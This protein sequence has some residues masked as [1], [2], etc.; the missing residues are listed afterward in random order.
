LK[1]KKSDEGKK[2][3]D[4]NTSRVLK[5]GESLG[6]PDRRGAGRKAGTPG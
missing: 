4:Y 5:N 2:K 6:K 1:G 3:V